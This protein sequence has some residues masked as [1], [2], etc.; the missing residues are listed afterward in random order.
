M[1]YVSCIEPN[2]ENNKNIHISFYGLNCY[3]LL[4]FGKLFFFIETN[5]RTA[6][7]LLFCCFHYLNIVLL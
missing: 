1:E 4:T 7:A 2:L 3:L 5:Y 6:T